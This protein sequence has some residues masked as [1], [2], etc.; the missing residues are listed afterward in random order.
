MSWLATLDE[1]THAWPA[2]ARW[3]YRALKWLLIFCGAYLALG[4]AYVEIVQEHR[5][6]L[7]SGIAVAFILAVGKGLITAWRKPRRQRVV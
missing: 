2:A 7:G 5:V 3:P 6:G 1:K 4:L